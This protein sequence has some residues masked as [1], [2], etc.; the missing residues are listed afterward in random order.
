MRT[1]EDKLKSILREEMEKEE[2]AGAQI[3]VRKDNREILYLQEG[4]ANLET[5]QEFQR[6]TITRLYSMTKPIT[7]VAAMILMEQGKLDLG[8]RLEEV[9]PEYRDMRIETEG[10]LGPATKNIRVCDL[11]HMTSGLSYGGNPQSRSSVE[12]EKLYEEVIEKLDTPSALST[13]EIAR[14][15]GQCPLAF[16]PGSGW[17]YGTSADVLGAVIQR[18]S[19]QSFGSFLKEFLLEPLGMKDTDFYVPEDKQIRLARAYEKTET[20]LCWYQGSHL[21]ISSQM[22]KAPVYESGGAGLAST[23]DDYAAFA[24]MLLNKGAYGKTQILRPQTVE[25][26]IS[27]GLKPWQRE[28]MSKTWEGLDGYSY[29][30]LMRVLEDPGQA[31]VLGSKGEYGWDGWLGSYFANSPADQLTMIVMCQK[32][33]TE[34]GPAFPIR[35]LKNVIWRDLVFS[36]QAI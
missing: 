23:V 1:M 6:N 11:L 31:C 34:S 27:S 30:N 3:L 32:K 22:R 7:A 25:Y 17:Q 21:G 24:Q 13:E 14:R 35:K 33:P 5:K 9:F 16:D 29:G 36:S 18:V 26:L 12:T 19:G 8:M 20:G 10:D 28:M 2:I 4:Y 15:L